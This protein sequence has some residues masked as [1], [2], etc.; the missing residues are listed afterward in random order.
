MKLES[1]ERKRL[2]DF[3]NKA[4]ASG[5]HLL[6]EMFGEGTFKFDYTEVQTYEDACE[7][8]GIQPIDFE[9]MNEVLDHN[10]VPMLAPHEI[11]YKKLTIIA[12]ALN[13]DWC[14]NWADFE[15]YKYYSWF[16]LKKE[17]TPAGV[18]SATCGG[19][20][21]SKSREIA[22]YFGNQF[23]DLWKEFLFPKREVL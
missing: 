10:Q 12:K 23:K 20:L 8:L 18:G 22:I 6:V 13:F 11:A 19:A 2:I 16:D 3:Y 7:V 9:E 5:K 1:I 21:A 14:P 15:E 4:D 17:E